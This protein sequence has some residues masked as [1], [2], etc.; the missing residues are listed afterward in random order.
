MYKVSNEV[1]LKNKRDD[2]LSKS[3]SKSLSLLKKNLLSFE[4]KQDIKLH[5]FHC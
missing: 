3:F 2:K 1:S 4:I 5:F